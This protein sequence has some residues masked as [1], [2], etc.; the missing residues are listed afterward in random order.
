MPYESQ[1]FDS[2]ASMRVEID[3]TSLAQSSVTICDSEQRHCEVS[4]L[5]LGTFLSSLMYWHLPTLRISGPRASELYFDLSGR[6]KVLQMSSYFLTRP[7]KNPS[8]SL[9]GVWSIVSAPANLN[10]S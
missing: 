6:M 3:Q 1:T 9:S 2:R 10:L 8:L 7:E 5:I 4:P